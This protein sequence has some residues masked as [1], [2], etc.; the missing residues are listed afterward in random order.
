MRGLVLIMVVVASVT[1]LRLAAPVVLVGKR[2]N[3]YVLPELVG[4]VYYPER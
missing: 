3:Y 1:G 2:E 4:S